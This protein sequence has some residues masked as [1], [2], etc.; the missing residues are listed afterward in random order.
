MEVVGTPW[1]ERGEICVQI[2]LPQ[3]DGSNLEP[4]VR[5]SFEELADR[6]DEEVATLV[7]EAV[8][9]LSAPPEPA[10]PPALLRVV[11]DPKTLASLV[12][13]S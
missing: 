6:S 10:V 3:K 7:A 5:L 13:E 9:E 2:R 1:S 4:I 12:R 11:S 8:A